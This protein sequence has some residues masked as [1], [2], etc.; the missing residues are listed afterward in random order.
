M[1]RRN[2]CRLWVSR[3]THRA[4]KSEAA[5]KGLTVIEYLEMSVIKDAK[6]SEKELLRFNRG[7]F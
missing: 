6:T 7:L 2:V 5:K 4:I 3:E 1:R